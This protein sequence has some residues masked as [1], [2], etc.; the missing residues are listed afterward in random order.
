MPTEVIRPKFDVV[1][2]WPNG[3]AYD[4]TFPL[5]Q[6][7]AGDPLKIR[8]GTIVTVNSDGAATPATVLTVANA[9]PL[10]MVIEG[11]DESDSYSGDYLDK[12][13]AIK[14]AFEVLLSET[15]FVAGA[16]APGVAVSV[17][18][19]KVQV[20]DGTN[21]GVGHVVEYNAAS[22]ILKLAFTF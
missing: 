2:G 14:G 11:N 1:R 15:M 21:V 16:Y 19:G 3:S 6:D 18:A 22:K 10:W 17:V 12:T 5:V 9:F 13:V 20:A 7:G 8:Q 4:R